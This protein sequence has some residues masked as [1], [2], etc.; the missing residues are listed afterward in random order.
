MAKKQN[1]PPT[2]V[3]HSRVPVSLKERCLE[4]KDSGPRLHDSESEFFSYLIS[5]GAMRYAHSILPAELGDEA[6]EK[7]ETK[8]PESLRHVAGNGK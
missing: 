6:P 3:V 1:G 7:H 4:L 8:Q 5:I 2:V